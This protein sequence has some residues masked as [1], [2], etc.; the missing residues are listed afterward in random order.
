MAYYVAGEMRNAKKALMAANYETCGAILRFQLR[1]IVHSLWYV[2]SKTTYLRLIV[3]SIWCNRLR[4][5]RNAKRKESLDG[6]E[7]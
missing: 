1:F 5:R 2:F 6:G 4:C 7:L 3:H